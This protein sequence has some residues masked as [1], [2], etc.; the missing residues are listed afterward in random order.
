MN[1]SA[2]RVAAENVRYVTHERI[3]FD[4]CGLSS[5]RTSGSSNF[6]VYFHHESTYAIAMKIHFL[7]VPDTFTYIS[8]FL[9]IVP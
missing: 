1:A 3:R 7:A 8:V 2:K 5:S 6:L 9:D 4:V